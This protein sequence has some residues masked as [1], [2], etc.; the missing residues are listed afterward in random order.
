MSNLLDTVVI[1]GDKSA[2]LSAIITDKDTWQTRDG[3]KCLSL[4]GTK[5]LAKYFN[6]REMKSRVDI[7]PS[8]SNHQQHGVSIW[9]G[10]EPEE[11]KWTRG[12]GEASR[13]NTGFLNKGTDNTLIFDETTKIDSRYKYMMATKRAYCRAVLDH[14]GLFDFFS[15]VHDASFSSAADADT[16]EQYDQE[17]KVTPKVI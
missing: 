6:V 12:V 16:K 3:V 9:V 11:F 2:P 1:C 10:N 15:D 13:L 14:L 7:S 17:F 4:P 8:N 5:K